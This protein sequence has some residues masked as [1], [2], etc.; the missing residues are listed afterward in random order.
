MPANKNARLRYAVIDRMLSAQPN[1]YPSLS[2]IAQ[3]CSH[4]IG[5]T[6]TT[7]CIEKD[8][9]KLINGEEEPVFPRAPIKYSHKN[10]GYY[11]AEQGFSLMQVNLTEEEWES[12]RYAALLL[13]QH[14]DIPIFANF[15]SAIER[16]NTSLDISLEPDE[17]FDKRYVQ[18]ENPVTDSGFRWLSV[19]YH[20]IKNRVSV[21]FDYENIYKKTKKQYCLFPYLLKE[22][23]NRWYVIGWV[24]ER[25]DYL[26]FALDR[27][28]NIIQGTAK[29]L[30]REDF[31]ID[32]FLEH[33]IGITEQNVSPTKVKLF[34]KPPFDRLLTLEP[35]HRSQKTTKSN[36]N[37]IEITLTTYLNP[38][39]N[40]RLLSIGP[41]CE[42]KSPEKLVIAM[43]ELIK[44]T[45]AQYAQKRRS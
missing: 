10:K 19:I 34:I 18:F 17:A 3:K 37:G 39:L 31:N 40:H 21:T 11:Y 1:R 32:R 23:R 30:P 42:V 4:Q 16:L 33:S 44:K 41:F 9:K 25:A 13:M 2:D 27:I 38:E 28:D 8:F 45:N 24:E 22:H 14:K 12:L 7:H 6:V 29:H 35:L 15:K 26:T 43:R 36:K 5:K 20:S